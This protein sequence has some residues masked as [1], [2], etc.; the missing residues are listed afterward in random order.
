[1]GSRGIPRCYSGFE[2]FLEE[3]SVR[4]VQRGHEVTVYNRTPFNKYREKT[5]KGV[6]IVHVPTIQTKATD[7]IVHT[8]LSVLHSLGRSYDI[9]YFCGVGNALW[10]FV[11]RFKGAKTLVNV[12]GADFARAKWS[13]FGR[14][15]LKKSEQWA[16]SLADV[17]IADHP[18][19]RQRY[20]ENFGVEA[21]LIPYGARVV[22]EDPGRDTLENLGLAGDGYFLY[23]SRLTP[24]NAADLTIEAYLESGATLPLV[25]V[26]DAPYQDQF[27]Q[28]LKDLAKRSSRV[29][30]TGYLFGKAYEQL[31]FHARAFVYPTAI[32]ATR[33]V[34]LDQMGFG[35]CIIARDTAANLQITESAAVTFDG[36]APLA[37]LAEAFRK[38]EGDKEL[39][40]KLGA[41]AQARIAEHYDWEVITTQYEKLFAKLLAR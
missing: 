7:T 10:A 14:L 34:L 5:F 13:G 16:A 19:I 20:R 21:E 1:M 33:P 32:D 18:S 36:K 12:D 9:V 22:T 31:S 17:V 3:I 35:N 23:V 11:P 41:A 26:G 24:E 38:V 6:E 39:A 4:L 15:W 30:L 8:V 27:L 37:S 29:I 28:K 25:V 2:T 40:Q